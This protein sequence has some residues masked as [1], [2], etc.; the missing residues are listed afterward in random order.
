MGGGLFLGPASSL[1]HSLVRVSSTA[2]RGGLVDVTLACGRG[3]RAYLEVAAVL[4]FDLSWR[5]I[6]QDVR[7]IQRVTG[8]VD[9]LYALAC[10]GVIASTS[11]CHRLAGVPAL[12]TL[13]RG[14]G[15]LCY[16]RHG[17]HDRHR[18]QRS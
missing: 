15:D 9:A 7:V 2:G 18:Q 17:G 13:L 3:R 1:L 14:L 5:I 11:H 8:V 10:I 4:D 16:G 12:D 6:L